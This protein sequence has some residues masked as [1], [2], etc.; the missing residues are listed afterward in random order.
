MSKSRTKLYYIWCSLKGRCLCETDKSYPKY[1]GRGI[2]VCDEWKNS[3]D[4]FILWANSNGYQEG[5][6]LSIDRI[7]NN[8]GYS[9]ENCR[10]TNHSTQ[11]RNQRLRTDTTIGSKGVVE[12]AIGNFTATTMVDTKSIHIGTY[13]TRYSA[14]LAYDVYL[15][16]NGIVTTYNQLVTLSD[17]TDEIL[18]VIENDKLPTLRTKIKC[19]ETGAIYNSGAEASRELGLHR[20]T[21]MSITKCARGKQS[22]AQGYHWELVDD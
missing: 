19:V 1:G 13:A 2:T 16:Q 9:P 15:L 14:S 22:T 8:K 12:T 11:S 18:K 4:A 7:D 5:K 6:R 3:S 20:N 21:S 10:W 17:I